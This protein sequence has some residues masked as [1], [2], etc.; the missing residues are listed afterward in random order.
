[1]STASRSLT[2]AARLP[3]SALSVL[4]AAYLLYCV[5]PAPFLCAGTVPTVFSMITCLQVCS[6]GAI[7]CT[8]HL[9][10]Q[11]AA[12]SRLCTCLWDVHT[13]RKSPNNDTCLRRNPSPALSGSWLYWF[14][15]IL[16]SRKYKMSFC[17]PL[18]VVKLCN[19][20]VKR[21]FGVRP[22]WI[23][24]LSVPFWSYTI[25]N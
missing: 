19:T 20:V 18:S 1:M 12:P 9:G 22:V 6:P 5:F 14:M 3:S 10:V 4:S 25:L 2:R 24:I 17:F 15:L 8:Y 7:G 13:V 11:Q 23:L 16:L 21:D